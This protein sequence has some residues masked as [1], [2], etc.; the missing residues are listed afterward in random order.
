MKQRFEGDKSKRENPYNGVYYTP[1]T[2]INSEGVTE[3]VGEYI[4]F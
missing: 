1:K 4:F 3:W 2:T